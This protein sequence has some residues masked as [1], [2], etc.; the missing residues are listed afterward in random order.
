MEKGCSVALLQETELY[1]MFIVCDELLIR[2]YL[3]N[4]NYVCN[5]LCHSRHC[6][7]DHRGHELCLSF[8]IIVDKRGN[9]PC[10]CVQL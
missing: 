9:E 6:I 10:V 5:L 1:V 4:L 2:D 3:C 7:V 8:A